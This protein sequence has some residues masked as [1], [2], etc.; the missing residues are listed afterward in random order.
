MRDKQSWQ[1]FD[2]EADR[3][4]QHDLSH[5]HPEIVSQMQSAWAHWAERTYF[6][7]W[8]GQDHT[9]WGQDIDRKNHPLERAQ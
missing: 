8:N 5:A 9:D 7:D 3:S 6:D 2:M 1:L 4:E